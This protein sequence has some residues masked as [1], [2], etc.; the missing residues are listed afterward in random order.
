MS[1]PSIGRGLRGGL[2]ASPPTEGTKGW[3]IACHYNEN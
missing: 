3:V 2:Y 1:L